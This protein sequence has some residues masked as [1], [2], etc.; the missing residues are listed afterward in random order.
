MSLLGKILGK[1]DVIKKSMDGIDA[2]VFTKE[3]KAKHLLDML[4]A[5]EPFMLIQRV[6]AISVASVYLS[7][8]VVAALIYIA[9]MFADPCATDAVCMSSHM[10]SIS[11]ELVEMN[12]E[13]LGTPFT[14]IMTLYIGG[15]MLSGAIRAAKK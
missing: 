6:L 5:Y 8:R 2:M 12:N 3:E 13:T 4:K 9:T 15:G 10:Q 14:A 11:A 1:E 7:L